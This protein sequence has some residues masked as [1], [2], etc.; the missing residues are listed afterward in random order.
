MSRYCALVITYNRPK[1]LLRCLNEVINQSK[2]PDAIIIIDNGSTSE[3]TETL[4]N[5][6]YV[7]LTFMSAR[8]DGARITNKF[9]NGIIIHFYKIQSNKGPGSAFYCG[10]KLFFE[11]N[12]DWLWVMD[13]DGY[14][15][16]E[17]LE[18][19]D[20][21][22]NAADLLN[23]LVI[24]EENKE[25]LAFGLFEKRHKKLILERRDAE[26]NSHNGVILS[27]ANP[28]N[29]TFLPRNLIQSIG[30]PLYQM[31]GWGVED[32][33]EKRAI[34]KGFLVATVAKALHFHPK[35]RVEQVSILNG[36]YKINLQ[37]DELKN[38]INLRNLSYIS[39]RYGGFMSAVRFLMAYTYFFITTVN[40][41]GYLKF[42]KAFSH[43]VIGHWGGQNSYQKNPKNR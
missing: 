29:G 6:G 2:K 30:F 5:N 33:Y 24:N 12:Y 34:K 14:P 16:R 9:K 26:A 27:A 10:F 31:Y 22:K 8:D 21:H 36:R 19:L 11:K 32:E 35:N 18:Y 39:A 37:N 13:D 7:D 15:D 40:I 42:V 1:L 28:F 43:G 20:T 4:I 17:C 3:T 41:L 25:L 23:S 38:Y